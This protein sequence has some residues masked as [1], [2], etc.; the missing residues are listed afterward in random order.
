M[1]RLEHDNNDNS[2]KPSRVYNDNVNVLVVFRALPIY[3]MFSQLTLVLISAFLQLL[4]T[5]YKYICTA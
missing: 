1:R 4:Y 2:C 3:Y 5:Q